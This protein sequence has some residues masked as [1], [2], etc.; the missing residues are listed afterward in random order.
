MSVK[1]RGRAGRRERRQG[2][3][4]RAQVVVEGGAVVA[5]GDEVAGLLE[6]GALGVPRGEG[7]DQERVVVVWWSGRCGMSG[8]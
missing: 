7:G 2:G 5:R 6:V 4:D 3:R 8:P 1:S